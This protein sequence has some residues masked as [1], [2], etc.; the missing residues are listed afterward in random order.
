MDKVGINILFIIAQL[1][2]IIRN[3]LYTLLTEENIL[4]VLP[5][6]LL[7]GL[8][9]AIM[10]TFAIEFESEFFPKGLESVFM[11]ILSFCYDNLGG[12]LGNFFGGFIYLHFGAIKMFHTFSYFSFAT[13]IFY[14][15]VCYTEY[16][17]PNKYKKKI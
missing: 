3:F 6:E 13:L 4:W 5:I 15:Y 16:I 11:L 12:F 7:N 1:A 17:S 8:T 9:F 10:W 14:C 2:F